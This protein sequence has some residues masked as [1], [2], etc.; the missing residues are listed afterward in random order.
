LA[1]VSE[2]P[3]ICTDRPAKANATCTVPSGKFQLESSVAS[4]SLIKADGTRIVVSQLGGSVIKLGLTDRSDLQVAIVPIVAIKSKAG[5]VTDPLSGFGDVTVRYKRRFTG[6][7]SP[8]LVAL[9]PFVKL[10]T[11]MRGIGNRKVEGG[12]ALPISISTAGTATIVLGPELD[13]LADSDGDGRHLQV[14]NLVN[15]SV[16]I[17]PRL[18]L[19]GE[20]WTATNFDPAAT[21]TSASADAALAYAFSRTA[22]LDL[23]ANIG[24]TKHI[25]R[26]ELYMGISLRF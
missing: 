11:A 10:P 17:A 21:V 4:W 5:G 26:A 20:L 12:L 13:L 6:D 23:G 15:L 22:Q 25:P 1:Q 8:V 7:G 19:A 24:L 18:T 3:P 2:D 16:P 9:F 14:V